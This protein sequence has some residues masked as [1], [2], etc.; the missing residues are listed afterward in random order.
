MTLVPPEI[1]N[2][3]LFLA[4]GTLSA[5]LFSMAKSGFGGSV[6]GAGLV[7]DGIA[8]LLH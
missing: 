5:M 8:K 7:Y 1:S 3:P 4:L 6:V 2:V